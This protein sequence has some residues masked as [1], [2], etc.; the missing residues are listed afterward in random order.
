MTAQRS[1]KLYFYL[2][3]DFNNQDCH[4][5]QFTDIFHCLKKENAWKARW[6]MQRGIKMMCS[7]IFSRNR[8]SMT[9]TVLPSFLV[10]Y[11]CSIFSIS[12]NLS[13]WKTLCLLSESREHNSGP[14][15]SYVKDLE[16]SFF[17]KA[18]LITSST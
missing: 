1:P 12:C 16:A 4:K 7:G 18:F 2:I 3:P 13:A 10:P 8:S 14:L 15:K 17:I 5:E 6:E 11:N 9:T